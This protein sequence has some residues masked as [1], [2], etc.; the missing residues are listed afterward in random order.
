MV[1]N[2]TMFHRLGIACQICTNAPFFLAFT[3]NSFSK[4][5]PSLFVMLLSCSRPDLRAYRSRMSGGSCESDSRI[6]ETLCLIYT[7][8]S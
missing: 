3:F 4:K 1:G 8:I 2:L 6:A 5:F 7:S